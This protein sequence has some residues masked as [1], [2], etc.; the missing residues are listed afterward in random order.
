MDMAP[1]LSAAVTV[2]LLFYA[3]PKAVS[4]IVRREF[5]LLG[6][7][8]GE[9]HY[10]STSK[11][12]ILV[13]TAVAVASWVGLFVVKLRAVPLATEPSF[14]AFVDIP[15]NMM[16]LMGLSG[17][18][19]VAAKAMAT[20]RKGKPPEKPPTPVHNIM[21]LIAD[22]E[23]NLDLGKF[24]MVMW[25]LVA[26]GAY[27]WLVFGVTIPN[28]LQALAEA[29]SQ[30]GA[31][32]PDISLPDVTTG[33]L[34]LMGASQGTYLG[35]KLTSPIKPIVSGISPDNGPATQDTEVVITGMNF[36]PASMV[37]IGDRPLQKIEFLAAGKL[38]ATVPSGGT[39]GLYDVIVTNPNGQIGRLK[40]GFR[41]I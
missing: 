32:L 26:A 1:Y 39:P 30:G 7:I 14:T 41:V 34:I 16:W 20:A 13:W 35:M 33:M 15:P 12:Q 28:S 9:D 2:L 22:N 19:F 3:I 6:L 25:T 5:T 31:K 4:L 8:K 24:Q 21:D 36:S 23:G 29:A 10:L 11:F 38:K 27:L 40:E 37:K 17:G 18:V